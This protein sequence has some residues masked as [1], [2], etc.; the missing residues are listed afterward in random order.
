MRM[1]ARARMTLSESC[2]PRSVRACLPLP[3][4]TEP[5][6]AGDGPGTLLPAHSAGLERCF[7]NEDVCIIGTIISVGCYRRGSRPTVLGHSKKK[8]VLF[9]MGVWEY[10]CVGG[11][12]SLPY[13]HTSIQYKRNNYFSVTA[14]HGTARHR[15]AQAKPGFQAVSNVLQVEKH[16][17][18]AKIKAGT[19]DT[20]THELSRHHHTEN[21]FI[22]TRLPY[23]K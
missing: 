14:L 7:Q 18:I 16:G 12:F 11:L 21:H 20:S 13:P 3:P 2:S 15:T 5:S 4:D 17:W 19:A 9:S 23:E 1:L 6:F 10:G 8:I 22:S